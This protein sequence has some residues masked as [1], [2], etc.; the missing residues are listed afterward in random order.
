MKIEAEKGIA[1]R[2]ATNFGAP[3]SEEI[4]EAM[5]GEAMM[6][7]AVASTERMKPISCERK[8][9][10]SS[11]IA[12]AVA[13]AAI[14]VLRSPF[15]VASKTI[16]AITPALSTDGEGRTK[17][18]KMVRAN[19]VIAIGRPRLR[20]TRDARINTNDAIIEKFVPLTAV[21]CE[22]PAMRIRLENSW[23]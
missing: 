5:L 14:P 1:S 4:L 18:T 23:L 21:K 20:K 3:K 7:P 10:M 15:R 22:I 12:T 11:K 9:S 19:N 13:R 16:R 17:R 2:S 6:I 8:G